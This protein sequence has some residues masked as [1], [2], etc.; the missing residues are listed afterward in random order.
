GSGTILTASG[1]ST[2]SWTP[3]TGLSSTT[4]AS[5]TASPLTNM[6]YT[7]TGTDANNCTNTTTSVVTV[8]SNPGVNVTS[9]VTTGCTP[10]CVVLNGTDSSGTCT[11]SLFNYGDGSTGAS[12]N[13]CY[14]VSGI[15]NVTFTC[16]DA[17]GCSSS[18]A[19]P[20]FIQAMPSPVASFTVNSG[21]VITYTG[22][23]PDS[24][25]IS[26][27]STGSATSWLWNFGNASIPASTLQNPACVAYPD[28]GLY[29]IN[30]TARNSAG[31]KDS[32]TQ[33]IHL[34]KL[35]EVSYTIPNVFSPNG[36]GSN[37]L[38]FIKN[39]GLKSLECKIYDRWGVQM[40]S[41][42]SLSGGWDGKTTQGALANDGVYYYVIQIQTQAGTNKEEK[43]YLQLIR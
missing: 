34:E 43:G 36:D 31:C 24:V 41:F 14:A 6:T 27:T 12:P 25:C 4:S 10:F 7:I 26:N 22:S 1:A 23:K 28:S 15:Y 16:T 33:C 8:H 40:S 3:A 35:A 11:T 19:K 30:L 37:D 17:N 21:L 38:F 9:A 29:C 18:I 42:N 32:T 20:G 2:Y 13:H 5:P 39:T